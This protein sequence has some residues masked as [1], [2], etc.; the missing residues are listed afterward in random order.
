MEIVENHNRNFHP[1]QHSK[2]WQTRLVYRSA[3]SSTVLHC[4][5]CIVGTCLA[6]SFR[7]GSMLHFRQCQSWRPSHSF[8]LTSLTFIFAIREKRLVNSAVIV[9]CVGLSYGCVGLS[10]GVVWNLSMMVRC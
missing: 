4:L 8:F 7:L 1:L 5:L 6:G 3:K 2:C 10:Y 9:W